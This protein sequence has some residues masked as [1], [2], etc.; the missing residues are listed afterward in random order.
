[1]NPGFAGALAALNGSGASHVDLPRLRRRKHR[2]RRHLSPVR[3]AAWTS[4]SRRPDALNY[5]T[6]LRRYASIFLEFVPAFAI[7]T[8]AQILE[9]RGGASWL[10]FMMA[11]GKND[12]SLWLFF[13]IA[14]YAAGLLLSI[15]LFGPTLGKLLLRLRVVDEAG[16]PST[17]LRKLL[18]EF[19]APFSFDPTLRCQ[20]W[21]WKGRRRIW[22]DR[23]LGTALV[24]GQ[25]PDLP[26]PD[27]PP[28]DLYSAD[29]SWPPPPPPNSPLRPSLSAIVNL[30]EDVSFPG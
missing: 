10:G 13:V 1:M 8:A 18:Y 4:Q 14:R 7:S 21:R 15:Q 28:D 24:F 22:A 30:G 25:P 19:A 23:L 11:S 12:S 3:H 20:M 27:Q 5:A 29:F 9:I 26:D 16:T 17:T 6:T 2:H